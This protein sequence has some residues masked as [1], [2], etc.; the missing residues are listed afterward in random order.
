M[1]F[2]A[3]KPS[4]AVLGSF[5]KVDNWALLSLH[6]IRETRSVSFLLFTSIWFLATAE[7]GVPQLGPRNGIIIVIFMKAS[8]MAAPVN[9]RRSDGKVSNGALPI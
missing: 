5:L 2:G 1:D 7:V 8:P 3:K 4:F 6:L 9:Y